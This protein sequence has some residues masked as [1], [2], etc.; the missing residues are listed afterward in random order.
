MGVSKIRIFVQ[1]NYLTLNHLVI[2]G[3]QSSSK[4][5]AIIQSFDVSLMVEAESY[6]TLCNT[7]LSFG[8]FRL[9]KSN[10]ISFDIITSRHDIVEK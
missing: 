7:K 8:F 4:M 5:R 9:L 3:L 10:L 1:L 2:F 6:E